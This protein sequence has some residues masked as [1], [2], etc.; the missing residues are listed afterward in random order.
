MGNF[1][2]HFSCL[3]PLLLPCLGKCGPY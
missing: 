2:D 1:E 3:K